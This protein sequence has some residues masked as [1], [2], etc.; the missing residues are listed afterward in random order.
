M[1]NV[2]LVRM[3][4]S[5]F[6][7]MLGV[8]PVCAQTITGLKVRT[9][10]EAAR[11]RPGETIVVQAQVF[12]KTSDGREGR[13]RRDGFFAGVS[14]GCVSKPFRFQGADTA[15]FIETASS[16]FGRLVGQG[17]GQYTM[18]DAFL[19]VA[20]RETGKYTITITLN[21]VKAETGIDVTSEAPAGIVAEK[22]T[23][24]AETH[25]DD[26]YRKLA[27]H[28][29]PFI[30]QETWFQPKS[31]YLTRFDYDGDWRGNNN[32][33]NLEAGSSQAY[34]YYTAMETSTHVFLVYN[35]FHPRDYSDNCAL[36]SCHENDNE[37]IVLAI[38]K[39]G[40]EFGRLQTMETLAHNNVHSYVNDASIRPG[41]HEIEAAVSFWQESHPM[42]FVEAGGHGALSVSDRNSLF[43]G[44]LMRFTG[45]GVTYVPKGVAERPGSP[46]AREVG[47][48]LLAIEEHWWRKATT[49][50]KEPTF[51]EPYVYVPFGGRPAPRNPRLFGAFLGR[52]EAVNKARPFWGWFDTRGRNQRIVNTGQWAMDPAYSLS[53]NM[54]F[55]GEQRFSLDYTYN[56]YLGIVTDAPRASMN[57]PPDFVAAT[58]IPAGAS[59][60][61][62]VTGGAALGGAGGLRGALGQVLS[63]ANS[64]KIGGIL[65]QAGIGAGGLDALRQIGGVVNN[66]MLSVRTAGLAEIIV[67]GKGTE[68]PEGVEVKGECALPQSVLKIRTELR[69]GPVEVKT[70]EMPAE[71]NNWGVRLL[72]EA[73]GQYEL[74]IVW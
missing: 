32:W 41:I 28:W 22:Q 65:K 70:V 72:F 63:G 6:L 11:V 3:P 13:L 51:D 50:W 12:G 23:F 58:A 40:S 30:A 49:D 54:T 45:T 56:P 10:P 69:S 64:E 1:K 33:D 61:P 35:F 52:K 66:C 39:D 55:P 20:P 31:D 15:S 53:R 67:R 18:K 7:V 17:V 59:V 43:N 27:L 2:M 16:E 74:V 68:A 25:A 34:V 46:C 38:Q 42:V 19:F 8:L 62:P 36:G 48:E 44:A 9:D 73:A 4:R 5:A 26:P 57:A 47:Y 14:G 60:S 24:G 71:S 21:D 29:A 37:G